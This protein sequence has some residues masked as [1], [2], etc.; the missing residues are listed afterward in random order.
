MTT[1][2]FGDGFLG[3]QARI[4][5]ISEALGEAALRPAVA[6]MFIRILEIEV[7][8]ARGLDSYGGL[9]YGVWWTMA[10]TAEFDAAC[11]R[12]E[13]VMKASSL[14]P[15]AATASWRG[16]QLNLRDT[17]VYAEGGGYR[18]KAAHCFEGS[19]RYNH[20]LRRDEVQWQVGIDDDFLD[21]TTGRYG[22]SGGKPKTTHAKSR[23]T[24]IKAM[25]RFVKDF[26]GVEL[27]A[28]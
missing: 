25:R 19:A 21:C 14:D 24:A 2:N 10:T 3:F 6:K 5:A 8:A 23:E 22:Y 7:R 26:L 15:I 18:L 28:P 1:S 13:R 17:S 20:R 12:A 9:P 27:G 4:D 11:E 16:T